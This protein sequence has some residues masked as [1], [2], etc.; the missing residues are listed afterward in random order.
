MIKMLL[1]ENRDKYFIIFEI[2]EISYLTGKDR[3]V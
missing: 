1:M 2:Q 3:R